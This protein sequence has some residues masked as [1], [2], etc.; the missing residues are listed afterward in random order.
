MDIDAIGDCYYA[1]YAEEQEN[2]EKFAI[3]GGR[4][5][6]IPEKT[7]D[8]K[9]LLPM[10]NENSDDYSIRRI[11]EQSVSVGA[12]VKKEKE[13]DGKKSEIKIEAKGEYN[14]KSDDGK[15]EFNVKG[16]I[17]NRGNKSA[18]LEYKRNF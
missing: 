12:E 18:E 14:A 13:E 7:D 15:T 6:C 11:V 9:K 4:R 8:F 16:H 17:D 3:W 1:D 2:E 5:I 10:H